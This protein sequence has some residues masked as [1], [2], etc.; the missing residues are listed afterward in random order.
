MDTKRD[1]MT[2]LMRADRNGAH[3]SP[4]EN[5]KKRILKTQSVCAICGK[6]V[7]KSL[8]FPHPMSAVIDHVIPVSRGGHPSDIKNLQLAHSMCNLAK[9]DKLFKAEQEIKVMGNRNLPQS[10]DWT[11]SPK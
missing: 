6:P 11:E 10:T 2:R 1:A 7:D 9:A 5:N 8:K 4:F 3:R